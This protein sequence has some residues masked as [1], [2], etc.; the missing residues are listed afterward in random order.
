MA[1]HARSEDALIE[2]PLTQESENQV[3]VPTGG[4]AVVQRRSEEGPATRGSAVP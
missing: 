2:L 4:I 3:A 1:K